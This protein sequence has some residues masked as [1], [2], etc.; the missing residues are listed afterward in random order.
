M[1]DWNDMKKVAVVHFKV[2]V[3]IRLD[4]LSETARNVRVAGFRVGIRSWDLLY[5]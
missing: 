4:E 5:T 3:V 2:I 1:V